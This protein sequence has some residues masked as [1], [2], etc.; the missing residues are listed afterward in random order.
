MRFGVEKYAD[1]LV[2]RQTGRASRC[3]WLI[4]FYNSRERS[5]STTAM[6]C[7]LP[8]RDEPSR[9]GRLRGSDF[10]VAAGRQNAHKFSRKAPTPDAE[11][12]LEVVVAPGALR[13]KRTN[14]HGKYDDPESVRSRPVR[15]LTVAFEPLSQTFRHDSF[16]ASES[17]SSLSIG[18][19]WPADAAGACAVS[20]PVSGYGFQTTSYACVEAR[21]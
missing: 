4:R 19:A 7:T 2:Q 20:A 11:A 3:G 18:S 21:T 9:F 16:A 10:V 17:S 15:S 5:I 14:P 8:T 13:A 6:R 1:A 12:I